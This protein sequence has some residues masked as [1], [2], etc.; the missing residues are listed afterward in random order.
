MKLYTRTGDDGSTG[1]YGGGRTLKDALRVEAYGTVDELNSA[2]GL[3]HAACSDPT[4]RPIIQQLQSRLFDLGA[5]L[6]TPMDAAKVQH[7][8][9]IKPAHVKELE[10]L[11]DEAS[12]KS[13]AL[14]CFILPGGSELAARLHIARTIAR[15]AER[16]I[17]TLMHHEPIG[18]GVV[19]YINRVSDLLFAMARWANQ[20]AG[21][22]DVPWLPEG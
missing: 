7:L 9:R 8:V 11:I 6:C 5:D 18:E 4:M 20:I 21:V 12:A 15:R 22:E 2:L 16:R 1:L 13:P 17:V 14:H 10:Q 3:A 19:P